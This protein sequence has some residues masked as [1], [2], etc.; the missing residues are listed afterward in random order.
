MGV[1]QQMYLEGQNVPQKAK[2]K[3]IQHWPLA[4]TGAYAG[5]CVC[6]GVYINTCACNLCMHRT[7]AH[8]HVTTLT[9]SIPHTHREAL[10]WGCLWSDYKHST[11]LKN[12][13]INPLR[14]GR[15]PPVQMG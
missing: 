8:I 15:G 9:H 12:D 1:K 11:D 2:Q 3:E 14:V 7:H 5:V 6:M 4:Y 10:L 13:C